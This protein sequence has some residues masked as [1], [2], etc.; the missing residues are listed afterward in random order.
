VSKSG[1]TRYAQLKDINFVAFPVLAAVAVEAGTVRELSHRLKL[2]MTSIRRRLKQLEQQHLVARR[3]DNRWIPLVCIRMERVPEVPTHPEEK[4]QPGEP[5]GP[6]IVSPPSETG[7]PEQ[8]SEPEG[9]VPQLK[10]PALPR[11]AYKSRAPNVEVSPKALIVSK[12]FRVP[13]Y[14]RKFGEATTGAPARCECGTATPLK[15]GDTPRCPLCSRG[16]G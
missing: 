14:I 5:T 9:P 16:E 2:P 1:R 10:T 4:V 15:Y 11:K 3:H 8:N 13:A 7:P 6:V 12:H